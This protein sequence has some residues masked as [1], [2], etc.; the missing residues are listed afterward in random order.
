[1]QRRSANYPKTV[2]K[3]R[4][5]SDNDDCGSSDSEFDV[6][7]FNASKSLLTYGLEDVADG[8][9]DPFKDLEY[10]VKGPHR[11]GKSSKTCIESG[12]IH[13]NTP[14]WMD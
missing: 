7:D 2:R 10:L 11:A 5:R 8:H 4:R 13:R 3:Q 1:M 12:P 6:K 9:L 14:Q